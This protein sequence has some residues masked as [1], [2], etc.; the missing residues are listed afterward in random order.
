MNK[1]TKKYIKKL[2]SENR[3]L[4]RIIAEICG[5]KKKKEKKDVFSSLILE[6]L[7]LLSAEGN[8][9]AAKELKNRGYDS[10]IYNEKED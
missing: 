2:E 8:K 9:K 6:D 5:K 7:I 3:K 4:K 1:E 10:S